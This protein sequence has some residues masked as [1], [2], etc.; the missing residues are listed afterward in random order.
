M[1]KPIKM[2]LLWQKKILCSLD[3]FVYKKKP[4]VK[5]TEA[6]T[7]G[8]SVVDRTSRCSQRTESVH[9]ASGLRIASLL[10]AD[11]VV[12]ACTG[13]VCSWDEPQHLQVCS[14]GAL[15][16]NSGLHWSWRICSWVSE[17]KMEHETNKG[18]CPES[19]VMRALY[20]TVMV[21]SQLSLKG[22]L[23]IY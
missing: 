8:T 6:Q 22:R 15:Q 11:H 13:A 19:V 9:Y 23:S 7:S 12:V 2:M 18:N 5:V 21:E 17:D 16:E 4:V 20:Q 10:L 14:H 3:E 1:I